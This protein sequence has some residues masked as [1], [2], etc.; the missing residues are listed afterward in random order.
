MRPR[1]YLSVSRRDRLPLSSYVGLPVQKKRLA[2]V[3]VDSLSDILDLPV[4]AYDN[5]RMQESVGDV[6]DCRVLGMAESSLRVS[7]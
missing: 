6:F 7:C 5:T 2:I 3:P 4:L 1:L